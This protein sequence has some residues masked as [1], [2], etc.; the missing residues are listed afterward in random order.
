MN[1]FRKLHRGWLF[2]LLSV[3]AADT[4]REGMR[5]VHRQGVVM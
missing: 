4:G 1:A 5:D 2:P 3:A